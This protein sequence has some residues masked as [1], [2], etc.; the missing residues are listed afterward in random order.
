VLELAQNCC[1]G[2][3]RTLRESRGERMSAVGSRYQK[4]GEERAD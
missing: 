1:G 2:K 4:T 3:K